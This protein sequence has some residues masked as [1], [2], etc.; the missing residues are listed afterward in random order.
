LVNSFLAGR[1]PSTL[2]TPLIFAAF[3][4][5]ILLYTLLAGIAKSSG[6]KSKRDWDD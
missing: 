5:L 4:F 3:S 6:K 2:V 1:L